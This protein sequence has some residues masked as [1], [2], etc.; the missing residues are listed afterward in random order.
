MMD[1]HSEIIKWMDKRRRKKMEEK[2]NTSGK[3]SG[4]DS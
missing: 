1:G 3:M 2:L 4:L